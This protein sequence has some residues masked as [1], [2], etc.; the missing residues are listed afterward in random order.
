MKER[1]CQIGALIFGIVYSAKSIINFNQDV[2]S[3]YSAIS[4]LFLFV[5]FLFG[6]DNDGE[7]KS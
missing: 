1:I 6:K 2:A 4:M 3:D 5:S 7:D